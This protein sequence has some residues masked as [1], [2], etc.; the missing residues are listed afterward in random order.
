MLQGLNRGSFSFVA[1]LVINPLLILFY[2]NCTLNPLS[3]NRQVYQSKVSTPL[4]DQYMATSAK[5]SN[6]SERTP[7]SSHSGRT[8]DCLPGGPAC[9]DHLN[10]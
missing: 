6:F 3:E 1:L 9:Q 2:Q 10:E 8:S 5:A 4:R 7:A